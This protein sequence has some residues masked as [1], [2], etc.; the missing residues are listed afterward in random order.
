MGEG[1][2]FKRDFMAESVSSYMQTA[3]DL[4]ACLDAEVEEGGN[5]DGK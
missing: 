5:S 3:Q 1:A 4:G 2:K